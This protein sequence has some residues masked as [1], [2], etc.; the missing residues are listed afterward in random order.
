MTAYSDQ[1][2]TGLMEVSV[3]P[4]RIATLA[5]RTHDQPGFSHDTRKPLDSMHC[6]AVVY[7]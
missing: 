7:R 6:A 2:S 5:L 4:A 3:N 1:S